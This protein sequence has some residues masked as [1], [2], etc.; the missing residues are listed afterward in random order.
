MDRETQ[1][2][3][4]QGKDKKSQAVIILGRERGFDTELRSLTIS[5]PNMDI[6]LNC[7]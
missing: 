2:V 5:Y 7:L 6:T 1:T 4:T 3:I